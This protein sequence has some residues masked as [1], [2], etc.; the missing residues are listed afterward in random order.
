MVEDETAALGER[1]TD[2]R[3]QHQ[4]SQEQLA[5]SLHVTRQAVSN[6]ERNKSL[7][8]LSLLQKMTILFG[9]TMDEL[10]R[11]GYR[12]MITPQQ[13]SNSA[14]EGERYRQMIELQLGNKYEI[15]IGLFYAASLFLTFAL[16]LLIAFLVRNELNGNVWLISGLVAG[17]LSSFLGF[18]LL[19]HVLVTLLRKD[20]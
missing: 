4:M 5:E 13:V 7:P 3:K 11:G 20:Q 19:A 17:W 15:S 8:D 6:W 1:I 16:F 2:L 14:D 10:I 9:I 12:K 18:G